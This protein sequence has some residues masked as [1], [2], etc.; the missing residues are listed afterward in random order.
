MEHKFLRLFKDGVWTGR[1]D[2]MITLPNGDSVNMDEYAAEHGID[3]PDSGKKHTKK[4][5]KQEINTDIEETRH[6]DMEE[7]HDGGDSEVDDGGDS[8]G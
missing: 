1:E 5:K 3:L 4:E 7:S 6:E 8:E 2:R